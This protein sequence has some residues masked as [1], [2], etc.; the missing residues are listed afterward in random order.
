MS[1]DKIKQ[2]PV[3]M[4]GHD[5]VLELA[6][7]F[8]GCQHWRAV[9]DQKLAELTCADCQAKLNPIE[10]LANMCKQLSTWDYAQQQIAKARA[11]LEE[12]KRCRCTKCG[13]M[14]VIRTVHNREL[15]RIKSSGDS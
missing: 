10:F 4:K 7:A 2:L 12:R 5:K 6:P 3:R 11:E 15:A 8:V 14:T 1:D 13:E 9:V